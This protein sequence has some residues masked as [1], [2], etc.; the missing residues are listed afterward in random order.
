[1]SDLTPEAST[2]DSDNARPY[3][4]SE[5]AFALNF[6]SSDSDSYTALYSDSTLL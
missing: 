6:H 1:M 2:N 5:L 4:V 3:S